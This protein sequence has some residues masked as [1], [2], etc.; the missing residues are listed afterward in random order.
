MAQESLAS[1]LKSHRKP[2]RAENRSQVRCQ[3]FFFPTE[4][5]TK[6]IAPALYMVAYLC[7]KM[8]SVVRDQGAGKLPVA[9]P[10]PIALRDIG[11]E[12]G[13]SLALIHFTNASC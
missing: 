9:Y 3:P 2:R 12:K 6:K 8:V 13:K 4:R 5:Q 1:C 7:D 10:H 11:K